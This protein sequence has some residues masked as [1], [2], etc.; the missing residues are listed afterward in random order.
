MPAT[1]LTTEDLQVFKTELVEEF[2]KLLRQNGI[3]PV[4]KWLKSQE[5]RKL[6]SISP[7]TLQNLRINGTLPFTKIGG[8][9]FYDYEDIQKML[10]SNK[11]HF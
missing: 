2:K 11:V 5:V 9:I 7:G 10:L 1:I 4:K 6:L 3:Q 8:V